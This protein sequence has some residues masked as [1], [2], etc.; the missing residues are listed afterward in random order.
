M[1]LMLAGARRGQWPD[2]RL[3]ATEPIERLPVETSANTPPPLPCSY[4]GVTS[5]CLSKGQYPFTLSPLCLHRDSTR[6]D[7][8][9]SLL[10]AMLCPLH[11]ISACPGVPCTSL[12]LCSRCWC[13]T[14]PPPSSHHGMANVAGRFDSIASSVPQVPSVV[15]ESSKQATM[16][17][18]VQTVIMAWLLDS[19]SQCARDRAR[20]T[21]K[22]VADGL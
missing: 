13:S 22:A 15:D 10:S 8:L 5:F 6:G 12:Y 18:L 4:P 7:L 9:P 20:S 14:P 3:T 17:A 16:C 2:S 1:V 19:C 21:P 11:L